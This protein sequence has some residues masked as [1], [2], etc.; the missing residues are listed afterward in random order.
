MTRTVALYVKDIIQNMVDSEEFIQ[1]LS[2]E[3]ESRTAN[4][5][6]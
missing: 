3:F 2:Y 1:G 6:S 5:L 4:S